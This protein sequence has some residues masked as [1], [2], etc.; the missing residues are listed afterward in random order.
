M[1]CPIRGQPA[2][3]EHRAQRCCQHTA[4]SLF[5]CDRPRLLTDLAI[6]FHFIF[7]IQPYFI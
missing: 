1:P 7:I 6:T 4:K 5:Q 2:A 3:I